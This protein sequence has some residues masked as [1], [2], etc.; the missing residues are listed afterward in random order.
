MFLNFL[1]VAVA[2]FSVFW[3]IIQGLTR[4]VADGTLTQRF[5]AAKHIT[6]SGSPPARWVRRADL[7][8]SRRN[9]VR[10][11]LGRPLLDD[12]ERDR[13]LHKQ[14]QSLIGFFGQAPFFDSEEARA[15]MLAELKAA[16]ARWQAVS[17]DGAASAGRG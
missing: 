12:R 7:R 3:L 10:Q 15:L 1:L 2:G 14:L 11:V 16:G 9:R 17:D 13:L 4:K 8:V 5:R 6:G